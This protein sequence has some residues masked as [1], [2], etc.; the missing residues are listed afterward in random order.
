[1]ITIPAGFYQPDAVMSEADLRFARAVI[2]AYMREGV[3]PAMEQQ[4]AAV[5]QRI[6]QAIEEGTDRLLTAFLRAGCLPFVDQYH[7]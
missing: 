3:T 4:A 1:M 2:V 5:V 6:D 7:R